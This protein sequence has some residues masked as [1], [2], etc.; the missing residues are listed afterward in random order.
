[1]LEKINSKNRYSLSTAIIAM[2]SMLADIFGVF[3]EDK[4]ENFS[5]K[6][7][8]RTQRG[9]V[10][11]RIWWIISVKEHDALMKKAK[12]FISTL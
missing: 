11:H 3:F 2:P 7:A 9:N 6:I 8:Q 4:K 12:T 5:Y 10:E 1:M